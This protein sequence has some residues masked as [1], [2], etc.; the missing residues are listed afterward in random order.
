MSSPNELADALRVLCRAL[1]TGDEVEQKLRRLALGDQVKEAEEKAAGVEP[2]A[3]VV[4]AG[5]VERTAGGGCGAVG[6]GEVSDTAS[7][8]SGG[9]GDWAVESDTLEGPGPVVSGLR[10]ASSQIR[11]V[12]FGDFGGVG[13]VYGH[14]AVP[15]AAGGFMR[16]YVKTDSTFRMVNFLGRCGVK[17]P[18]RSRQDVA[19]VTY[20]RATVPT[21]FERGGE[22]LRMFALL[23][24]R[25]I[26]VL[27]TSAGMVR[28]LSVADVTTMEA[29]QQSASGMLKAAEEVGFTKLVSFGA[30]VPS[31]SAKT[32]STAVEAV[33]G[34]VATW[35]T[36]RDV[37]RVAAVFGLVEDPKIFADV[38]LV[39]TR[40][41]VKGE[42]TRLERVEFTV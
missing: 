39:E 32:V 41:E 14:L 12:R 42:P 8:V 21:A 9:A 33:L 7:V 20:T 29:K 26:K 6:V 34:V 17:M 35:R 19:L 3:S 1:G 2:A 37:A 40:G 11:H 13:D 4:A 15:D 31:N 25:V 38:R 24:D 22:R 30:N 5:G 36:L 23:G 10:R 27:L 16:N 28:G 18:A